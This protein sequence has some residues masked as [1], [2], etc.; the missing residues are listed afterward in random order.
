MNNQLIILILTIAS[1]SLA[2]A[3][4]WKQQERPFYLRIEVQYG[5]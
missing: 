4:L 1:L 2:I 3:A 5:K